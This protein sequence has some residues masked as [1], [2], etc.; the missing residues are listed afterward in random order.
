MGPCSSLTCPAGGCCNATTG[1]RPG[2][3]CVGNKVVMAEEGTA[4][5]EMVEEM[6]VGMV[7]SVW[8]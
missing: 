3:G 7:Q 4:V 6:V 8:L 1:K 5:M 2:S